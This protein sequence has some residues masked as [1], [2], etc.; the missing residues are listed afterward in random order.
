VYDR[1]NETSFYIGDYEDL[2]KSAV[3]PYVSI[4]DAYIQNRKKKVEE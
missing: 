2:K 3:D 4:R 1:V